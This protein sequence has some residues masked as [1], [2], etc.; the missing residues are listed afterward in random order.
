M[1]VV[2]KLSVLQDKMA[3]DIREITLF[4]LGDKYG[5]EVWGVCGPV[6]LANQC[7]CVCVCVCV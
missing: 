3:I 6:L 7:V 2:N 5:V 4:Y 1:K